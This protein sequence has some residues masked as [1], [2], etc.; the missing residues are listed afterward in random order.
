M[1]IKPDFL[2]YHWQLNAMEQRLGHSGVADLKY[3]LCIKAVRQQ[4][5]VIIKG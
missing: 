3:V 4:Q 1:R 2:G 5:I